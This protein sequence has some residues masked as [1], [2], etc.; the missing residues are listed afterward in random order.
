MIEEVVAGRKR[1]FRDLPVLF[2]FFSWW[3]IYVPSKIFYICGKLLNKTFNYFS[4][5]LLFKTILLPWKRDE[6]D[7]TNMSLDQK[8]QVMVMNMISRLVGA[9]VR[10]GTIVIGFVIMTAIIVSAVLGTVGFIL[11]PVVSVSM[12]FVLPFI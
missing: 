9:V 1:D 3:F 6:I 5:D 10:G 4:I 8:L 11:I 12:I 2:A 7:T